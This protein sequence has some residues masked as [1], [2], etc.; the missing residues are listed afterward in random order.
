MIRQA[1]AR[2]LNQAADIVIRDRTR[3][4]A[5]PIATNPGQLQAADNRGWFR[6]LESFAG[7]WQRNVEITLDN[8]TTHPVVFACIT[9]IADDIA[10]MRM[11][12]VQQ[13]AN[14]IWNEHDSPAFSPVLRKPNHFQTRI[15]FY[16]SW[17][18]SKLLHGN[19]YALK[20]RDNRRVVQSMYA[21]DPQRVTPLVAPNG[22]VY[23]ELKDDRLSQLPPPPDGRPGYVVPASEIIHDRIN[24]LFHPLVGLSPIYACGLA[25]LQGLNILNSSTTFFGNGAQPGGVITAPGTI[26]QDT[27]DRLKAYF[28]ANFTG[29]NAGKVA[30]LGDG[31]KYEHKAMMSATDSQ[32]IEQLKLSGEL[33]CMVFKVPGYKVGVGQMP[34]H[35]NIEALDRQY[36]SQCLQIHSESIELCLDEGLGLTD[37]AIAAER[38][39][40]EFDKDDLYTLDQATMMATLEKGK[41]YF[42][43]NEGRR[44][45][46][47]P[48]VAGGDVVYRQQQDFSL[49]ALN[50]RDAKADPFAKTPPPTPA[51]KPP[52]P[53][54]APAKGLP[55]DQIKALM[56][57]GLRERFGI[58]RAA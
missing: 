44:K 38:L 13:D 29:D 39:G 11:R 18:F 56:R 5:I 51:A 15:Q 43:P 7:A 35:N 53:P 55:A 3:T 9:L 48:P 54:P 40:A 45:I 50:K 14:G 6:I 52:D 41:N 31:L 16:Q 58:D 4:K 23:Y 36:Y 20:V 47:L 1:F 19:T 32:I 30:I 27:A 10:K 42:K 28:D 22:D 57:N 8:V 2:W 24:A 12:L 33:I 25:A 34:T 17:M 49:E 37:G 46:N 21:L 26:H